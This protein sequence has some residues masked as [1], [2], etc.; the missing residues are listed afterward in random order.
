MNQVGRVRVLALSLVASVAAACSGDG[1]RPMTTVDEARSVK[2][3]AA[4]SVPEADRAALAQ[5]NADFALALYRR[6]TAGKQ[7]NL[8][9]SPASITTAL[10][11]VYAGARGDTEAQMAQALRFTLPQA[12]LHPALNAVDQALAMRGEGALASD[13]KP[14]RLRMVNTAWAQRGFQMLPSYLDVLAV[15]YG[16]GVNL[17]DFAGATEAARQTI[18]R[19]V[20]EKTEDRIKDLLPQ[21]ALDASTTLVLT[22]AVYFNAAWKSPFGGTADAAFRRLDGSMV[23]V[24]TM[25]LEA[26]LRAA[27]RPDYT[28]VALPYQDERLS[29]LVVV[30]AEGKLASVEAALDPKA[31]ADLDAALAA[32]S[33]ILAL[34]RFR[35]ETPVE[36]KPA[37]S[38]LG[39]PVAFSGAADFSGIDGARDL[40]IQAVLHKAFIAV[41]EKG[42]EA[43]AATAVVVGR[44]SAPQGLYVTA[45]R[46]FLFF[47]RDEPTGAI[48]FMGR[49]TDPSRM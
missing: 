26:S 27:E 13:G 17:L 23:N 19:W 37:L 29:M 16:A 49:V 31:L 42:T 35:F 46:P 32:Q 39:M 24:P 40:F 22:N 10:A 9:F 48:L 6:L 25:R 7:D 12:Q 28:A 14:F 1:A 36:L 47:L 21:G 20:E 38:D 5:G 30:P 18:N 11:M 2:L 45:N 34:P 8:V 33:V 44:T 3:R 15:S 4:P 41:A 43:A